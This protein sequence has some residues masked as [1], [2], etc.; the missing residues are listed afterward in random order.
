MYR[1]ADVKLISVSEAAEQKGV[2]R[3]AVYQAIRRGQLRVRRVLGRIGV[4]RS[5]LEAYEPRLEKIAAGRRRAECAARAPETEEIVLARAAAGES[6]WG[7]QV[8]AECVKAE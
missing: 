7:D 1:I 8:R 6:R 3:E 5:S 2:S 4:V